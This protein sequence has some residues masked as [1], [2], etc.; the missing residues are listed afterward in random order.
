[1]R[2]GRALQSVPILCRMCRGTLHRVRFRWFFSV[3]VRRSSVP[4]PYPTGTCEW[5]NGLFPKG[6]EADWLSGEEVGANKIEGENN[7]YIITLYENNRRDVL[8][9]GN[10]DGLPRVC[11]HTSRDV[12]YPIHSKRLVGK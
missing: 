12:S 9:A 10:C 1:M 8:Q 4:V 7:Y 5:G 3:V 2:D 6:L 11:Q